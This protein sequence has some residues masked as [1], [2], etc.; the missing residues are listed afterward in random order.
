M[1]QQQRVMDVD[2]GT[3][4]DKLSHA[5]GKVQLHVKKHARQKVFYQRQLDKSQ[6]LSNQLREELNE[7]KTKLVAVEH[8]AKTKKRNM[9]VA[10]CDMDREHKQLRHSLEQQVVKVA[11]LL[12]NRRELSSDA[13]DANAIRARA[14]KQKLGRMASGLRVRVLIFLFACYFC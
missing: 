2:T 9:E 10:Q 11:T 6:G 12:A 1:S 13:W 3:W 4:A 14:G 7:A 8:V 5:E